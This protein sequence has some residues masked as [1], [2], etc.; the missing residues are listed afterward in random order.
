LRAIDKDNPCV[1]DLQE[2]FN[3]LLPA[4]NLNK[5]TILSKA[6]EYIAYLER[7]NKRLVK[8]NQALKSHTNT[9]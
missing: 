6:V 4:Q 8:E 3:G 7:R 2:D 5:A 9:F 1:E